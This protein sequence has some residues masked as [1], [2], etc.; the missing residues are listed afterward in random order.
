[1][2]RFQLRSDIQWELM[3]DPLPV[4]TGKKAG[5]SRCHQ[6][7]WRG[8]SIATG[9]GCSGGMCPQFWAWQTIWT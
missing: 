5:F 6:I 1:M 7:A 4:P 8:P 2:S 9:V 3:R